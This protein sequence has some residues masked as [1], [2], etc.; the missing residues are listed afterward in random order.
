M[1]NCEPHKGFNGKELQQNITDN[2]CRLMKS[3]DCFI[4][5]YNAQACS[6]VKSGIIV[7]AEVLNHSNDRHAFSL[8][9]NKLKKTIPGESEEIIRK[10][11]ILADNGYYS[12]QSMK[13][14][15]ENKLDVYI[16][17]VGGKSLYKEK[18]SAP[19]KEI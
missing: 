15:S 9:C 2:D 10:S 16:A 17:D 4:P 18:P 12:S 5:A 7:A 3:K 8:I 1:N 19:Q 11:R 14:A 6:D 13:Y